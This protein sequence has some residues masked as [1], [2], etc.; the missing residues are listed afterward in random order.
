[1]SKN[2]VVPLAFKN[3]FLEEPISTINFEAYH[4]FPITN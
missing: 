1:M 3:I 2:Q 4:L